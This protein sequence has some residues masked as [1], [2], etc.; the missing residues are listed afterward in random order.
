M[1]RRIQGKLAGGADVGIAA[2]GRPTNALIAKVQASNRRNPFYLS[3]TARQ[4]I[5]DLLSAAK[6]GPFHVD[7]LAK[8]GDVMLKAIKDNVRSQA[9][10]DGSIF[11][12]LSPEYAAY[13]RRKFGFTTPIL[14]AT[15]DLLG[16]LRWVID[17]RRAEKG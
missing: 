13:K 12:P 8:I 7:T 5:R 9:N 17:R 1:K 3:R 14:K 4:R 10:K 11:A 2:T 6:P 16:G 15:N